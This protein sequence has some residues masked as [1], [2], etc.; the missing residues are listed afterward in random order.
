MTLSISKHLSSNWL[1]TITVQPEL[2]IYDAIFPS[3]HLKTPLIL[4]ASYN[5]CSAWTFHIWCNTPICPSQNT[6]HPIGFLQ[7][8]FSLNFPYMMQYS[9]LSISKHLSFYWLP[10]ITVQ[11]ELSIYDAILPSVHLKTPLILLA[12]Y[13]YCSAWTFHIW[14]NSPNSLFFFN[15]LEEG[16]SK[17]LWNVSDQLPINTMSYAKRL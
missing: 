13:N 6:C 8:L 2:S 5:Y 9:H 14:C 17:L 4:L 12:S 10:T 7:L 3:V 15:N 11:P 1:P 16:R